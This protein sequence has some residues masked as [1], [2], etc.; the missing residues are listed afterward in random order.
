MLPV[1]ILFTGNTAN[2]ITAK[3][4]G[5]RTEAASKRKNAVTK[6]NAATEEGASYENVNSEAKMRIMIKF[7]LV[8][9]RTL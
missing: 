2:T 3:T 6:K 7:V 5:K 8:Y 9:D 4:S 1:V